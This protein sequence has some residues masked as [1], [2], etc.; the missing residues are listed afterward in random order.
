MDIEF[1]YYITF[2]LCRAAGFDADESYLIAYSS[3]YTDDNNKQYFIN[4]NGGGG[5]TS[6]ISQT[7]DI[8][9]P[10]KKLQSI[11]PYFHF[12]PAGKEAAEFCKFKTELTEECKNSSFFN[13][14]EENCLLTVAN[15]KNAQE[16][17]DEALNSG[18]LFRIGI[19]IHSFADT[20]SHQYFMGCENG[21]NSSPDNPI[22]LGHAYYGH[23]PDIVNKIWND[24]RL[25][26]DEDIHNIDKFL[27]AAKFIFIKL[28]KF[29]N[30]SNTETE[31]L[32]AYEKLGLE[33][34]LSE[35][36]SKNSFLCDATKL[37]VIKYLKPLKNISKA[38]NPRI[39]A[40]KK[41]C[42]D[43][44]QEKFQYNEK[45]WQ[46]V[47]FKPVPGYMGFPELNQFDRYW[48]RDSISFK[49]SNWYKFQKALENQTSYLKDKFHNIYEGGDFGH[50]VYE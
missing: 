17:L 35:A 2:I 49:D 20:W 18:D 37:P 27:E 38:T 15:S 48:E 4:Y 31:S 21:V 22:D 46:E 8:T 19:A 23:K 9:K 33:K 1:H 45:A 24:N 43:L 28:H 44:G 10:K 50:V 25:Q 47:A 29:K 40:Y 14:G 34:E 30:G 32:G 42:P 16:I 7:A 41:L 13:C 6:K 39:K 5:F 26:S 11:Y 36:M 3:Q 12:I